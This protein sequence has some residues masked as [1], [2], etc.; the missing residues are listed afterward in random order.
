MLNDMLALGGL[1]LA[2]FLA[3]TLLP[4]QSEGVL[5]GLVLAGGWPVW[6]LVAVASLGNVLGSCLNW[7]IGRGI[8]RWQNRPWFPASP[9]AL[10]RAQRWYRRF[11]HWSLLL[12]W[13]PVIGDPLTL[14]AGLM[15]EP[16]GRFLVVV[17]AAKTGRY[18]VLA[19]ATRSLAG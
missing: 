1:F 15:R 3:A 2:A 7:W 10:A 5:A 11:G 13:V 19:L 14:A 18:V 8:G 16:F 12:S 17:G 4:A 6:L 9:A